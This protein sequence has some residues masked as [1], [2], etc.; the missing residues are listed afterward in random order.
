MRFPYRASVGLK[1]HNSTPD[2][3]IAIVLR[4]ERFRSVAV[5]DPIGMKSNLVERWGSYSTRGQRD[6]KLIKR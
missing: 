4:I 1:F 2:K 5:V 6:G 3:E